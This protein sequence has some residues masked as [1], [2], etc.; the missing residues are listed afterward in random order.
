MWVIQLYYTKINLYLVDTHVS[1]SPLLKLINMKACFERVLVCGNELDDLDLVWHRT[2]KIEICILPFLNLPSVLEI[3][4]L[5]SNCGCNLIIKK[6]NR[7]CLCFFFFFFFFFVN[8]MLRLAQKN[9]ATF[10]WKKFVPNHS[11]SRKVLSWY[12][13]IG[14]VAWLKQSAVSQMKKQ[15]LASCVRLH[16]VV[17]CAK[18]GD[19][20]KTV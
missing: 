5:I 1:Y 20:I 7:D 2:A 12:L 10:F 16:Q 9:Y 3:C 6:V 14:L 15:V 4:S 17:L 8:T 19:L 18:S 11:L 13:P